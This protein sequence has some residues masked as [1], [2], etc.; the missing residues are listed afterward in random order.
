MSE[1][2]FFDLDGTITSVATERELVKFLYR[3][4][5]VTLWQ[6]LKVLVIYLRYDLGLIAQYA[7]A[8]RAL[9]RSLLTGENGVAIL[10]QLDHLFTSR[11][12]ACLNTEALEEIKKQQQAGRTIIVISSTLDCIVARYCRLLGITRWYATALE[13]CNDTFTGHAP[14]TIYYGRSKKELV[15]ALAASEKID[16]K[17]S[18][19]YGDSVQDGDMLSTVGHAIAVNPS[20]KMAAM[21]AKQ[22]WEIRRWHREQS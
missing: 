7:D 11:L 15:E 3:Q 19:A 20:R 6:L 2:A 14:G 12:S 16:L 17:A 4:K 21:A 13:M 1:A 10:G 9:L 22:G 5:R 8:K 18:Y